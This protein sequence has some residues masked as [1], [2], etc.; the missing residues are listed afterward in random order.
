MPEQIV[1]AGNYLLGRDESEP[2]KQALKRQLYSI[3][4]DY[5]MQYLAFQ[6]IKLKKTALKEEIVDYVIKT[7]LTQIR[8]LVRKFA[9]VFAL[10]PKQVETFLKCTKIERRRWTAERK[11]A[12]VEY[13]QF[14]YGEFPVYDL[15][16]ILE[17]SPKQI[18]TWRQEYQNQ[19]KQNR[20]QAG[21][22][23][24]ETKQRRQAKEALLTFE[25]QYFFGQ[26]EANAPD[27][28]STLKLAYWTLHI[29]HW[30]K[31]YELKAKR[32]KKYSES[33]QERANY[34]SDLKNQGVK[35]LT[36]SPYAILAFFRPR[37]S[38]AH[39]IK[40]YYSLYYLQLEVPHI[41]ETFLFEIPYLI[42]SAFFPS[43]DYLS[44]LDCLYQEAIITDTDF[45]PVDYLD[46]YSERIVIREWELALKNFHDYQF[47]AQKKIKW[48]EIEEIAFLNKIEEEKKNKRLQELNNLIVRLPAH[49]SLKEDV[50][51]PTIKT[52]P[53]YSIPKIINIIYQDLTNLCIYSDNVVY[54][55][56]FEYKFI[57][58]AVKKT[59]RT[60]KIKAIILGL[61]PKKKKN[62]I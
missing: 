23:A 48:Q 15:L 27:A 42:G 17:I 58:K 22:K 20:Q 4:K 11:L 2:G 59:W 5:L 39:G 1:I 61:L 54:Y 36:V 56:E 35:Q 16:L 25:Y 18:Q 14:N 24:L 9:S 29:S 31:T 51:I 60:N 12:V 47:S 19:V 52:N 32:A 7:P 30:A 50:I 8:G 28:I 57:I 37:I 62:K 6:G 3:R 33:Y 44:Q 43:S 53:N 34:F 13:R 40:D 38:T 26:W 49:L 10:Y 45:I 46:S 41:Q 55:P 21:K